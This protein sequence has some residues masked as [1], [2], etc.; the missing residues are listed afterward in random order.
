MLAMFCDQLDCWTLRFRDPDM[1]ARYEA[2]YLGH[3]L[4]L[5]RI[6]LLG[7]A[8][9]FAAFGLVDVL[10][11]PP[12]L[13]GLL[14]YSRILVVLP[15]LLAVFVLTF[16]DS[17]RRYSQALVGT[18]MLIAGLNVI[19]MMALLGMPEAYLHYTGL[20]LAIVYSTTV[21]RIPLLY[22][23]LGCLGLLALFGAVA[24]GMNP[25]LERQFVETAL[26]LAIGVGAA[27]L[28]GYASEFFL[29]ALFVQ[30]ALLED[31]RQKAEQADLAKSRFLATMS[32]ELRTPLNAIIGFS[33]VI[34]AEPYGPLGHDKYREYLQ[35]I[36]QS[37]TFLGELINDLFDLTK[38]EAGT[39]E[40][41]PQETDVSETVAEVMAVCRSQAA[42]KAITMRCEGASHPVL[43]LA[44]PR[45][46]R[47]LLIN[48]VSNSLK[49]TPAGGQVRLTVTEPADG[50]CILA[51]RD[52]GPGIREADRHRI[53][54]PFVQLDNGPARKHAGAGLGLPLVKKI[55]E[56]HDARVDVAGEAGAGTAICVTF[57]AERH[58]PTAA[59][60]PAAVAG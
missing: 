58:I 9:V 48:L 12:A 16:M 60:A 38:A 32:H 46:L 33:E 44:D 35:H 27:L 25:L 53:F 28:A 15:V 41:H 29:R 40:A 22:V 45:L 49:F 20:L 34:Q 50:G 30:N 51:V 1:E 37:G 55:A 13:E 8:M 2:A 14:A 10:T 31:A 59:R 26:V 3:A 24:V 19:A 23:A 42:E 36:A 43:L 17:L 52:T 18:A 47:Q 5:L 4:P 57:P 21:F 7:A 39:L 56:L 11:A 6:G 54:E